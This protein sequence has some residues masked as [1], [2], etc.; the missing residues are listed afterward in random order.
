MRELETTSYEVVDEGMHFEPGYVVMGEHEPSEVLTGL[1]ISHETPIE[2]TPEARMGLGDEPGYTELEVD[3][4]S[5]QIIQTDESYDLNEA[6]ESHFD[7]Q[8][9]PTES[10]D[11]RQS[12]GAAD[13]VDYIIEEAKQYPLLTAEEEVD[14]A[15]RIEEGDIA[16]KQRLVASNIRLGISIAKRHRNKGLEFPDLIQE[17]CL[18]V[19]RAAEKFDYRKGFK[20]STYATYWINH[21]IHRAIDN[22]GRAIQLPVQK[23]ALTNK[24][25]GTRRLLFEAL[26]REPTLDEVASEMRLPGEIV[27]DML[28][29]EKT[30]KNPASLDKPIR[31]ADRFEE[32][33]LAAIIENPNANTESELAA[34]FARDAVISALRQLTPEQRELII[35]QFELA[36]KPKSANTVLAARLDMNENVYKRFKKKTLARLKEVMA[37]Q[38]TDYFVED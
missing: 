21:S 31:E 4:V 23:L 25:N 16:A 24:M 1:S 3:H 8:P 7:T 20:F 28:E 29:I 38:Q 12:L 34:I 5:G 6:D 36:G 14:L 32:T 22:K 33:P 13:A 37:E 10:F 15:K 35:D 17:A 9:N 19:M 11:D 30:Q 18:G 2:T 26:N 27:A